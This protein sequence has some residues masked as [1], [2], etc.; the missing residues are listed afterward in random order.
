MSDSETEPDYSKITARQWVATLWPHM[1]HT[2]LED[3]MKNLTD[4]GRVRF[5]AY[6]E[7]VSPSTGHLHY[8]A[9]IVYYKPVRLSQVI[10]QFGNGHHFEVMRGSLKQ[11]EAYCSK[12]GHFTKLGNEPRQGERHDLIQG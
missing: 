11:N 3:T 12:E 1:V 10:R 9:Y 6:G 8:Q 7:E 2:C 4:T 5:I